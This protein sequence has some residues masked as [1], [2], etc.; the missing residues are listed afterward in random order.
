[1]MRLTF[2]ML[3]GNAIFYLIQAVSCCRI[4]TRRFSW[5]VMVLGFAV[6]YLL[7]VTP[8]IPFPETGMIRGVIALVSFPLVDMVLFRDKWYRCLFCGVAAVLIM[9]AADM[10]SAAVL[11]TP[12]QLRQ[13]LTFQPIPVQ[14]TSY[15]IFLSASAF[16]LW[17]FTLLMNRYKYRLSGREWALY[18][19]FPVS[20]CLLLYGWMM[21]CR[22]DFSANRMWILLAGLITCVAADAALFTAV[23]G[24]AQRVELQA[25]NDLLA[26]QID[27][28]K[29]HYAAITAQ[30][31]NIRRIRHDI[32][33]HLYTMD[34]LLKEGRYAQAQDYFAEVSQVSR[35]KSDLG[36]CENPVVDAFL[37]ARAEDLKAQGFDVEFQVAVPAECGIRIWWWP[38]ATYWT[39]RRRPVGMPGRSESPSPPEWSGNICTSGSRTRLRW[40]LFPM[41]GESRSWSGESDIISSG[42]WPGNTTAALRSKRKTENSGRICF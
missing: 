7:F 9:S 41:T 24:M 21:L 27:R 26:Q 14:L 33:N 13:G 12:E 3:L 15:A 32:A 34:L 16:F 39:T 29:E 35:Y 18:L 20:Q 4:L 23:R 30:Y 19:L 42:S 38:S 36:S 40:G 37:Y 10:I 31:E 11:L 28:Q 5:P 1:M 22:L 17:M 25:E 8:A 6:G 2:L